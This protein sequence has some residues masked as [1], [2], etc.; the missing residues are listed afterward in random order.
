MDHLSIIILLKEEK[1]LESSINL[2]ICSIIY[3]LTTNL[4]FISW[5]GIAD[6]IGKTKFTAQNL[7]K[8]NEYLFRVFACNKYGRGPGLESPS[9]RAQ[10]QTSVPLAPGKPSA[11]STSTN[12]ITLTWTAPSSDG[13]SEI[14]NYIVERQDVS[15]MHWIR[16]D[17]TYNK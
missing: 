1:H 9:V 3:N 11:S 17:K 4:I 7:V 8:N 12:S 5:V 13:G 6:N 16:F 10:S 2:S 15:S 14:T